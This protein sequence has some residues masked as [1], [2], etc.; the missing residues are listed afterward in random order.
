MKI[1]TDKY[2]Y[3]VVGAGSSG[4]VLAG[5]LARLLPL[6]RIDNLSW[7][8]PRFQR[9][10]ADLFNLFQIAMQHGKVKIEIGPIR[11]TIRLARVA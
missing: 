9:S 6:V 4:C 8:H 2:G 11:D 10:V 1:T 3:I 5:R 7:K